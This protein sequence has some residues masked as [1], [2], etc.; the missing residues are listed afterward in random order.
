MGTSQGGVP[1]QLTKQ[2]ASAPEWQ[3]WVSPQ[4]TR[5]PGR[6]PPSSPS[7]MPTRASSSRTSSSRMR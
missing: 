6:I 4:I 1:W 5:G 7:W 2:P 3:C